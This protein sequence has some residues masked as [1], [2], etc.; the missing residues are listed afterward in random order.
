ME[1]AGLI[2]GSNKI[3]SGTFTGLGMSKDF[4]NSS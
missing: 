3:Q 2:S 1:E 4:Y